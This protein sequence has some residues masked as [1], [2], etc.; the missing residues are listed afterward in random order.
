MKTQAAEPIS[1]GRFPFTT[2]VEGASCTSPTDFL[3]LT[4]REYFAARAMQG[5]VSGASGNP[6]VMRAL[7]DRR[8]R[9]TERRITA[10]ARAA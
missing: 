5:L 4:K 10:Q 2:K 3:G 8:A 7:G 6:A 1:A 9:D